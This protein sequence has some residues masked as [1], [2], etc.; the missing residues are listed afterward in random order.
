MSPLRVLL[1]A[2][3]SLL[4]AAGRAADETAS[5][6]AGAE[7]SV[8]GATALAGPAS[9][10]SLHSLVLGHATWTLLKDPDKAL[11]AYASV[12]HLAGAGPTGKFLGDFQAASNSE[13]YAGLRLYSWWLQ[14]D[15]D[16]WSF[17]V[18][19]LL[20]DDEFAGTDAG[21][22]FFNSSFGWPA[23][24]S[25]DTVNTGPAFYVA[26]PGLRLEHT[27]GGGNAWRL[28]VFDGD[29]FDSPSGDP[30]ATRHGLHYRVGGD[31]G[32]F[33]ITEFSVAPGD[34]ATRLTAGVWWHTAAFADV[35]D[36]AGGRPFAVTGNAPREH[37]SNHGCYGAV[38]R[39]LAGEPGNSGHVA[40]FLRAGTAPADRNA[41]AWA[42]DA[43]IAWTGPLAMR[44]AD[45]IALGAARAV[46]GG[47]F[48]ENARLADPG[49]APPDH[50]Q[51]IEAAYTFVL[52]EHVSLQPD[53]QYIMHPGGTGER[54]PVLA[55]LLR[56]NASF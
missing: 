39:T 40:V 56:F 6:E 3:L 52:N 16:G 28:G 46:F 18:G 43:G 20:A 48:A 35:R 9:G 19:A 38:E 36:D 24:I 8:E 42:A 2:G 34:G 26:A 32:W 33:L 11:T 25:A 50:E 7:V 30:H 29:S 37:A 23:F 53:L 10:G 41:I 1:L 22:N 5:W 47:P 49:A 14:G 51:V 45:V 44:P 12:L 15:V 21:A 4:P 31:Q 54:S 55:G 17:R 27:W 13:G